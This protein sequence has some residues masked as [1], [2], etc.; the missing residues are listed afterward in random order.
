MYTGNIGSTDPFN[1]DAKSISDHIYSVACRIYIHSALYY[2]RTDELATTECGARPRRESNK[3]GFFED[4]GAKVGC[5][6]ALTYH[7]ARYST[8]Y[9]CPDLGERRSAVYRHPCLL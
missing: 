5:S 2:C 8:S 3:T 9:I 1:S 7:Q 6:F 4:D